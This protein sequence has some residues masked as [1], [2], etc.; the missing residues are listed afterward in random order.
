ASIWLVLGRGAGAGRDAGDGGRAAH[1]AARH[2]ADRLHHGVGGVPTVGQARGPQ[3]DG[4]PVGP[5]AVPDGR[6]AD[7]A[8]LPR[9][10]RR[11]ELSDA[12][13]TVPHQPHDLE[14]ELA[15]PAVRVGARQVVRAARLPG[16][17][18]G[19][20]QDLLPGAGLLHPRHRPHQLAGPTRV[21]RV[22]A[23]AQHRRG[24]AW[25]H[26]DGA[27]RLVAPARVVPG[28]AG[29]VRHLARGAALEAGGGADP[30][31]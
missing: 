10:H 30:G 19:A 13:G 2:G 9:L 14:P 20:H 28:D 17:P 4:R 11:G 23:D 27:R 24:G 5:H 31:V 21:A 29:Q 12:Q 3:R 16:Q 7:G 6:P 22:R 8:A 25:A 1:R 15:A 26:P 18:H